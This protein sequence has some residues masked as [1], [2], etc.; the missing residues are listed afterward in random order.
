MKA[1]KVLRHMGIAVATGALALAGTLAGA[2]SAQAAYDPVDHSIWDDEPL[3]KGWHVDS[4]TT[5]LVMQTDGNLVINQ[6]GKGTVWA[7]GTYGCG[8]KA[9]MQSDGNL[10]VYD[11]NNH[12]CWSTGTFGHPHARLTVTDAGAVVIHWDGSTGPRIPHSNTGG[13]VILS[14]DL[15]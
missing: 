3:Y 15:Y 2:G 12:P 9:V 5:Q 11:V 1:A 6:N 8:Y 10:V 13:S 7:S 4:W 14:S